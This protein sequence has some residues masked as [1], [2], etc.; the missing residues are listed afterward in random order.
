MAKFSVAK[1]AQADLREIARYTLERWGM[2]Q[3]IQ[4]SRA[5]RTCFQLLAVNP[6]L[7]R[8][9]KTISN[10][11]RRHEQGKHTVFYRV[12]PG[13]VR[14]VRILHQQVIP[15]KSHFAP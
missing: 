12:K 2:D 8:E 6:A 11:L 9:C 1:V 13:G 3:S 5:L 4:Y 7:G 10:G 15:G 14:I